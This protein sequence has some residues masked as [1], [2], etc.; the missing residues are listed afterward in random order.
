MKRHY[1]VP[2]IFLGGPVSLVVAGLLGNVL[3]APVALTA[4]LALGML[5]GRLVVRGVC[6]PTV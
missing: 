4:G 6:R 5:V 1:I 3:S 2:S